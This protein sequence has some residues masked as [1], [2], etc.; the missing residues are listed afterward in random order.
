[1]AKAKENKV[2]IVVPSNGRPR[3]EGCFVQVNGRSYQIQYDKEV[4]VPESVAEVIKASLHQDQLA[5]LL[6]ER[7]EE[8]AKKTK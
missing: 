8:E 4:I 7:F 1:M 5:E 2:K 6:M 3:K